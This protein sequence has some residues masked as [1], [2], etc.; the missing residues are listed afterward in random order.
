VTTPPTDMT[1]PPTDMTTPPTASA[2]LGTVA[3]GP[4]L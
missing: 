3:R 4:K 2:G 1:T